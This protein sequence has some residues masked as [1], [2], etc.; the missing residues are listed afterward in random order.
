MAEQ[1]TIEL[2]IV[3]IKNMGTFNAQTAYEK[4]N[5]V[6]Y[7][8]S[9]YCALKDTI[10]NLPTNAEY[11]QLYA[12]KGD[13]GDTGATG[14]QG[15][16]PVKG[17]DYYTA[18]DISDI[19]SDLSNTISEVVSESVGSLT[20]ATPL[21]ASSTSE[22]TDTTRIYVNTTDG[23]WYWYDGADWQDGGA[24]ESTVIETDKDLSI[25]D[26]AA[27]GFATG[28]LKNMINSSE[29]DYNLFNGV[30]KSG[31]V[32]TNGVYQDGVNSRSAIIKIEPGVTY[33]VEKYNSSVRWR[34]AV[35]TDYP[36]NGDSGTLK[37]DDNYG[38]HYTF[39]AGANDK[40]LVVSV[41]NASEENVKLCVTR[42][43]QDR[44]IPYSGNN[45]Q[46]KTKDAFTLKSSL[47]EHIIFNLFD[48]NFITNKQVISTQSGSSYVLTYGYP[49][50][51]Y[52]GQIK[53][54]II[55][56]EPKKK[57]FIKVFGT[58]DRFRIG[59]SET[60]PEVGD[61]LDYGIISSNDNVIH[62]YNLIIPEDINYMVITIDVTS[63]SAKL[64]VTKDRYVD[65]Y[66]DNDEYIILDKDYYFLDSFNQNFS[67]P[68]TVS[69]G[70]VND[71]VNLVN[72]SPSVITD[73]YDNLVSTYPTIVTKT[74]LGTA[75]N[76]NI[77]KYDFS[78]PKIENTSSYPIK[79][80]K[81]AIVA[82]IHG[83]EQGSCWGLAQFMDLLTRTTND[84]LL[85]AI[86]NNIDFSIIPCAN[87]YGF[88]HNQ[89]K[90]E[91]GIDINRNFNANF[92]PGVDPTSEYYAGTTA[93]SETETQILVDFLENN[94]DAVYV[95]DYHNVA[96]G[97]PLY[98]VN[99][100]A[101]VTLANAVFT[102]LSKQ[103]KARYTAIP[104]KLYGRVT[105]GSGQGT[106]V[107]YCVSKIGIDSFTLE[108]PW[109]MPNMGLIQYD[110]NT[111][112]TGIDVLVNT[113]IA[114]IKNI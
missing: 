113:I 38:Y 111:I 73:I 3:G 85:N 86:K 36:K 95:V 106:F 5:V 98:Y 33:C 66:L 35:F 49:T 23:H 12:E 69:G 46:T 70:S 25:S 99:K 103:W 84:S 16:K 87:P 91:N 15:P 61:S 7:Q 53:T 47:S 26:K 102:S 104:D 93:G 68:N 52:S 10:G 80:P 79:K 72:S 22:M 64:C 89:R 13:K 1:E 62:E 2:G 45:E 83:Y 109:I 57:Y 110:K 6:T 56:V 60:Y 75:S 76:Y 40:Y 42:N 108:T 18:Q 37:V 54:A 24:Y 96:N 77:N 19:E 58:H 59:F 105:N 48:G 43:Y 107:K 90:N 101:Q 92:V 65:N 44:F 31:I 21:A 78:F 20:T 97:Y 112:I 114:I 39:T 34:V 94:R 74:L 14:A 9:S 50:N 51:T 30:Y 100:G 55:R 41:T 8:G 82:G 81:I 28:A 63:N 4:L 88:A 17:V 71:T 11:W 67:C 32:L 27:D 29:I